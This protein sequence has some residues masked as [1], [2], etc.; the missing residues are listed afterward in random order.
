M[1]PKQDL[2]YSFL[3]DSLESVARDILSQYLEWQAANSPTATYSWGYPLY[4]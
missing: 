3:P 1:E 4:N 2:G